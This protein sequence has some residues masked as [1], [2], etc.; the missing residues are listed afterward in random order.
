MSTLYIHI[1]IPKTGTTAIQQ[2]FLRNSE[3]LKQY[4]ISY[5]VM[6]QR[7]VLEHR[8][9]HFL[10][11]QDYDMDLDRRNWGIVE[12]NLKKYDKVLLSDEALY[13]TSGYVIDFWRILKKRTDK[14]NVDLK[15]IFYVRRQDDFLWSYYMQMIRKTKR[16]LPLRE[17]VLRDFM[18]MPVP[19]GNW[20]STRRTD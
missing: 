17:S 13:R 7:G 18:Y 5:P 14:V 9:G 12:S 11:T 3:R 1:G 8:N 15:V 2:F 16:I 6:E 20:Y 19:A 10:A 4:G